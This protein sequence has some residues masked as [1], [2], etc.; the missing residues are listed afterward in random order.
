MNHQNW[1]SRVALIFALTFSLTSFTT[2]LAIASPAPK[3]SPV[4][5]TQTKQLRPIKIT[6]Q[7]ISQVQRALPQRK[8]LIEH[9]F[10]VNLPDFGSCIFVPVQE[11]SQNP[12]KAK[13]SLYL[14]KNNQVI[15]TFPQSQQV[16]PWNLIS[17]KAVSFL[18][19]DFD[20]PDED[21]IL[22][23]SN[24]TAA[25]KSQ[26]FPVA[27]LYHREKNGF[28]VYEDIS[29]K[30]TQRKVK[31]IAEAENILRKDFGFIP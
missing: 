8:L 2:L 7:E 12:K 20:G 19:L 21:G 11:F 16:R 22:L 18:E 14:V 3:N 1:L 13:L 23:I 28:K 24:Y 25:G 6:S 17:L 15:Y 26:T 29:K 5:E 27:T 31:T 30:L 10:R 9:A 4:V